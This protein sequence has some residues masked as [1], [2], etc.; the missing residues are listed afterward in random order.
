MRNEQERDRK[1]G[2]KERTLL[3]YSIENNQPLVTEYLLDIG[4]DVEKKDENKTP[5]MFAAK[6][7]RDSIARTLINHGAEINAI[8]NAR[9]TAFHYAAKYNNPGMLK[10]LYDLGANINIPNED[11]WTA[12]D[13]AIINNNKEV[14]DFLE[15][16]GCII[17]NKVIPDYFDGPYIDILNDG[18]M[19]VNY[20][21][22]RNGRRGSSIL[23][24]QIEISDTLT[25]I[26]GLRKDR[27]DYY[28]NTNPQIL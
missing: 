1:Y 26:K 22:N 25:H 21:I 9:N 19:M 23:S 20:L 4:F 2:D 3:S 24:R 8:N 5:L 17:F 6:Y 14:I 11:Q 15:S 18:E 10:L 12:L 13:F 7:G 27:N 28:I 16:I